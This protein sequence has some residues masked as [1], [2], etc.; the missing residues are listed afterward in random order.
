MTIGSPSARFS[1][2][3]SSVTRLALAR[4]RRGAGSRGGRAT[5][6]SPVSMRTLSIRRVSPNRARDGHEGAAVDV[7]QGSKLSGSTHREVLGHDPVGGQ[8]GDGSGLDARRVALA[9]RERGGGA[10]EGAR[11]REGAAAL[12]G[13]RGGRCGSSMAR[14]SGSRTVGSASMR[15]GKS[16]S[17]AMRRS[18]ATCWASF[19]P[20]NATSGATM[21]SSLATTVRRRRSAPGRAGRPRARRTSPATATVVREAVGIDLLH[22]RGRTA[23]RRRRSAAI[24][25]SAASSRG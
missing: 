25:A 3:S 22:R 15:T 16:R 12:V 23:R 13:A 8:G 7:R 18:T 6:A 11:E 19:W 17:R 2:S 5:R 1:A 4:P 10:A 9:R 21:F 24:A 14:P 20:K